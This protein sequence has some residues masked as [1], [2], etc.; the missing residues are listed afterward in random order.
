MLRL[1]RHTDY[2]IRTLLALA[3]RAEGAVVPTATIRQ[4]MLIPPALAIR[5]VADLARLGFIVTFPGRDGGIQLARPPAEITLLQV[6]EAFEGPIHVSECIE[7][8]VTCPFELHC[9]VRRRW[10]RVDERIRAELAQIT[11]QEL[12]EEALRVSSPSA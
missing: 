12:A 3:E 4:E 6:V 8:K 1:T 10:A 7:G 9:P 11:F 5:V 2:A